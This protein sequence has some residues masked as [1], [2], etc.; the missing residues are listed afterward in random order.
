MPRSA[1]LALLL[2]TAAAATSNGCSGCSQQDS[3]TLSPVL[4]A[5]APQ[6]LAAW[7][8]RVVPLLA[9]PG[10]SGQKLAFCNLDGPEWLSLKT[11]GPD[12]LGRWQGELRIKPQGPGPGTYVATVRVHAGASCPEARSFDDAQVTITLTSPT[13]SL[14]T[15]LVPDKGG[16]GPSSLR[17]AGG[18][19][20][21]VLEDP[22]LGTELWQSDGTEDGTHVVRDIAPGPSGSNPGLLI[23][24]ATLLYF[25][26]DDGEHGEKL[27]RSDGTHEGT[28]MIQAL[29][30]TPWARFEPVKVVSDR[31]Y[32]FFE[33]EVYGVEPWVTDGTE[34][35]TFMLEDINPGDSWSLAPRWA[36][37]LGEKVVFFARDDDHGVE[38]WV[39]DG[40]PEGTQRISDMFL[41]DDI[42]PFVEVLWESEKAD[43]LFYYVAETALFGRELFRTDGTPEGTL[44]LD[45]DPGASGS[46]PGWLAPLG[47][48][49]VFGTSNDNQVMVT[50]G[51]LE[52]TKPLVKGWPIQTT[53]GHEVVFFLMDDDARGRE[54]WRT[55]GTPKGTFLVR[56]INPSGDSTPSVFDVH[57]S[58]LGMIGTKLLFVANDGVS[59]NEPWISDG[60]K[61]GTMR[62]YDINLGPGDSWR[63][64]S[65]M[66]RPT[67]I[68]DQQGGAFF[69]ADHGS[70][71]TCTNEHGDRM[72]FELWHTDGTPEKTR[73]VA[74]IFSGKRSAFHT[75][76]GMGLDGQ[77]LAGSLIF[78]ANDGTGAKLWR[79]DGTSSGTRAVLA[80]RAPGQGSAP[81]ELVPLGERLVFSADRDWWS[82]GLY[83]TDGT[84]E[85]T[86]L[87]ASL[88][89]RGATFLPTVFREQILF[90]GFD[91]E[92]GSELWASDGSPSGTTL[93]L[94][95]EAGP[96]SA[97]PWG[98]AE[99]GG[100]LF[101]FALYP[102]GTYSL[103]G[104]GLW[105]TDGTTL[106]TSPITPLFYYSGPYPYGLFGAGSRVFFEC[107]SYE[108]TGELCVSDGTAEGT[109]LIWDTAPGEVSGSPS[110]FL[111]SGDLMYFIAAL[112]LWRSDGTPEGTLMVEDVSASGEDSASYT[113]AAP[114][115][116]TAVG[117]T[118]FFVA[119]DMVHGYELWKTDGTSA[120][121]V[122]VKDIQPGLP[123]AFSYYAP[124][125]FVAWDGTLYFAAD[126]GEHGSELWRS[127]GTAEGTQLVRD[128]A[129]GPTGSNPDWLTVADGALYFVADGGSGVELWRSDGT[130]EGTQI[131]EDVVPGNGGSAPD[132]LAEVGGHLFFGAYRFDVGRELFALELR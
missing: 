3:P 71:A 70:C 63:K 37:S 76:S 106:G 74:D 114:R 86:D 78:R 30:L 58:L 44:L 101:F 5:V 25:L 72:G 59:G 69:L 68:P 16:E 103:D 105:K 102:R 36:A 122:L 91:E 49:L 10:A 75:D 22:D 79:S 73:L 17:A 11:L 15:D 109:R 62:L 120:G 12:D 98:F 129:K 31:L 7:G 46:D 123:S 4:E 13:P 85:G 43:D 66:S 26:A 20:Y 110:F 108:L 100:E 42:R 81:R 24:G 56:D 18:R 39:T 1:R 84:P 113:F 124:R 2:A 65:D 115:P 121:T 92:R 118:V 34:A 77:V 8:S 35:G 95:L 127:D 132:Q 57:P 116:L 80:G 14:V 87:L 33:D 130:A 126:D 40:T 128:L 119:E 21:F 107:D 23:P 94:D 97:A 45:I 88:P 89:T 61:E 48:R 60:T 67:W 6:R 52:G 19:V 112:H 83:I 54:L 38:A 53:A 96:F 50:D 117:G 64:G 47:R 28:R 111:S 104:V 29:P 41:R 32:F 9:A 99:A 55:D 27:W 93:L 90:R 82:S 51:T 131:V 125:P